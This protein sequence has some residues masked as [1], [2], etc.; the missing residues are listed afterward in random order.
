VLAARDN[1]KIESFVLAEPTL[2]DIFI[3]VV[4]NGGPVPE[5][6]HV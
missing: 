2:D 3:N 1:V 6:A 4:Q 5:N